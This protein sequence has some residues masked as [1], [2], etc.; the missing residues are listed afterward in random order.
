MHVRICTHTHTSHTH[1]HAH[2]HAHAATGLELRCDVFVD[3]IDHIEITT[4]TRELL[5]EEEPE[6]FELQAFDD[7]GNMFSTVRGHEFSWTLLPDEEAVQQQPEPENILNFMPFEESTYSTDPIIR[8]LENSV[9]EEKEGRERERCLMC[10]K[11]VLSADYY[12][13]IYL[14]SSRRHSIGCW[15][16]HRH[17]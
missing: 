14:G 12:F 15:S 3:T 13:F 6:R 11:I 2:T 5:L 9:S 7:E 10:L 1:T 8:E 17:C 16:E 4:R